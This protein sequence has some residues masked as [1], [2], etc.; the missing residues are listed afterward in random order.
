MFYASSMEGPEG[1][2]FLVCLLVCATNLGTTG[3]KACVYL[4]GR[5]FQKIYDF[6]L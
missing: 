1:V 4:V 3:C 5:A 6:D 2:L